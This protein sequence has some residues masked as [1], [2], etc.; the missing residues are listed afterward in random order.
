M[1][2]FLSQGGLPRGI[3]YCI[4]SLA[5]FRQGVH[6]TKL[7][8][9]LFSF[10]KGNEFHD[11]FPLFSISSFKWKIMERNFKKNL[12]LTTTRSVFTKIS[13]PTEVSSEKLRL[14]RPISRGSTVKVTR[15]LEE[16]SIFWGTHLENL[17]PWESVPGLPVEQI[18]STGCIL[19][20][21][22]NITSEQWLQNTL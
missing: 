4:K 21:N 6:L 18:P 1:N 19:T 10:L 9:C 8:I 5:Y 11:I 16:P 20:Q 3:F 2:A 15:W 13:F 14:W 17:L 12:F 22:W 7:V